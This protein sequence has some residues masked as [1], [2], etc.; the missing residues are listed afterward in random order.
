VDEGDGVG[1]TELGMT[2]GVE[3]AASGVELIAAG[4]EL[5]TTTGVELAA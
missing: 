4:V 2:T 3:L 1:M 5:G